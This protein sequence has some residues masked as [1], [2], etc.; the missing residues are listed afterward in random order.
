MITFGTQAVGFLVF[1]LFVNVE[2][3]WKRRLGF[4]VLDHLGVLVVQVFDHFANSLDSQIL[5]LEFLSVCGGGGLVVQEVSSVDLEVN[6][7]SWLIMA[8]MAGAV[9]LCA[10]VLC[11]S[12]AAPV[13][14]HRKMSKGWASL[15]IRAWCIPTTESLLVEHEGRHEC[16]YK[17]PN[18]DKA[19]GVGYDLDDD[20]ETRRS[21]LSTVLADYDK[22]C[23][24]NMHTTCSPCADA[25]LLFG[26]FFLPVDCDG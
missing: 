21:E 25:S 9:L 22:V 12:M 14:A 11:A 15:A 13:E 24:H 18:G 19:V 8:K 7:A 5:V 16:V 26:V 4:D 17:L 1:D 20:K 3:F 6:S 2:A 23:A 10:L